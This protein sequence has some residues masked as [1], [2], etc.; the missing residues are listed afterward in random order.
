MKKIIIY[1]EKCEPLIL[2]D[3]DTKDIT[4]YS[5]EISKIT[6][7]SK[8]CILETTA[9]NLILKP[10]KINSIFVSELKEINIE[11]GK[12]KIPIPVVKNKKQKT[13][14]IKVADENDC[15]KD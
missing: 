15:I 1:Q 10:T 8:I 6:E 11:K 5:K 13:S 12:T 9:G 3:D 4:E 14:L 2:I 7:S